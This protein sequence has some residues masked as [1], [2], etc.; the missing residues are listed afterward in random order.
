MIVNL[1]T[2]QLLPLIYI[3]LKIL[4]ALLTTQYLK[5][6]KANM[7][8]VQDTL[9]HQPLLQIPNSRT[10]MQETVGDYTL[11]RKIAL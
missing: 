1:K 9:I 2:A 8:A 10:T 3:P 11:T 7:M 4:Q 6:V 5:I